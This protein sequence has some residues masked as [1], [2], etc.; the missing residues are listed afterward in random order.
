MS[1]GPAQFLSEIFSIPFGDMIASVGEGVATAQAKLDRA[2]LEA[3]LAVYSDT[4]DPDLK[5]LRE[6]GYQPTFYVIPK[7]SGK[8]VVALS[9]FSETTADGQ[10]LQLRAS[11]LNPTLSNKYSYS[12]NASAELAFDIVPVPPSEQI[13]QVPDVLGDA[14]ADA[15]SKLRDVGLE[16]NFVDGAGAPVPVAGNR[17]VTLQSPPGGSIV[18]VGTLVTLTLD[19]S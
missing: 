14:A 9:M 7:A 2:S 15:A 18:K 17:A 1:N 19:A 6:I 5:L 3:T 8:M 16:T 11:P 10:R 4:N 13:R 12:G